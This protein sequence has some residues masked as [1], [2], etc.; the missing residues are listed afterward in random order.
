MDLNDLLIILGTIMAASGIWIISPPMALIVLGVWLALLGFRLPAIR[1]PS[2]RRP[3][4]S[5]PQASS[6]TEGGEKL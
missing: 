4:R 5:P 1:L 2:W 3:G 6:V